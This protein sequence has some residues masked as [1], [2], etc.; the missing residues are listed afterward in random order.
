MGAE[1]L[2]IHQRE[3]RNIKEKVV[4]LINKEGKNKSMK[5][6]QWLNSSTCF[7]KLDFKEK[8]KE[9]EVRRS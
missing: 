5:I 9:V 2:Q 6:F 3:K 8:S 1:L 7:S 4:P